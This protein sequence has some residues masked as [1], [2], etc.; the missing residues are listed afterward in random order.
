MCEI[1]SKL[2]AKRAEDV[3]YDNVFIDKFEQI[4]QVNFWTNTSWDPGVCR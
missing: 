4:L 2:T 1:C 3:I